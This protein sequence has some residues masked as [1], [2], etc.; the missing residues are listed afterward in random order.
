[1]IDKR[2]AEAVLK[3][4]QSTSCFTH[5]NVD[6]YRDDTDEVIFEVGLSPALAPEFVRRMRILFAAKRRAAVADNEIE[7]ELTAMVLPQLSLRVPFAMDSTPTTASTRK[8]PCCPTARPS[9]CSSRRR[10]PRGRRSRSP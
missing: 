2:R 3:K 5:A 4:I 8:I 9:S 7:A 1:M 10:S 6:E